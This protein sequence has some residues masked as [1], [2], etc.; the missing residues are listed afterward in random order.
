MAYSFD[1]AQN[2]CVINRLEDILG[3]RIIVTTYH[4]GACVHQTHTHTIHI[5]DAALCLLFFLLQRC[6]VLSRFCALQ[7]VALYLQSHLRIYYSFKINRCTSLGLHLNYLF[8]Y[9]DWVLV[10]KFCQF[11][12]P[13]CYA[14][15]SLP[16]RSRSRSLCSRLKI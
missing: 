13:G 14:H 4:I 6:F 8:R 1:F 11:V 5:V 16:L 2:A 9:C 15:D 7:C 12:R 3:A 10:R